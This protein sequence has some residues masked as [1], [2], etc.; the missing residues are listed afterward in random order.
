MDTFDG[1][2]HPV[3]TA[4][5]K[6]HWECSDRGLHLYWGPQD[7]W[8][9]RSVFRPD[10]KTCSAF[11]RST[12]EPPLGE[13]TWRWMRAGTWHPQQLTVKEGVSP[14]G[15]K[16][17]RGREVDDGEGGDG[18]EGGEGD[19]ESQADAGKEEEEE[20]EDGEEAKVVSRR[21][22]GSARAKRQRNVIT[23]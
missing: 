21:G 4:N 17:G 6:T 14:E 3:G 11:C 18:G 2:Y 12:D 15:L 8:I 1:E 7:L 13:Q 16:R 22:G 5:G 19:D 10:Q 23:V 20:A 9:L